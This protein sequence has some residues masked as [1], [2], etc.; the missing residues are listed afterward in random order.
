MTLNT[1]VY[2]KCDTLDCGRDSDEIPELRGFRKNQAYELHK[3]AKIHGWTTAPG[4]KQILASGGAGRET[5]TTLDFCPSC[6]NL[7]KT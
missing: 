1:G 4:P 5:D 7:R 2:L 6:S 3:A